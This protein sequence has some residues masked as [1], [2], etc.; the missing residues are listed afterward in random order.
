[1]SYLDETGLSALWSKIKSYVATHGGGSALSAYPVGSIYISVNATNPGTIFGGTWEAWGA[2]R[3]P[4]GVNP[5]DGDF[6]AP[7]K[8]GGAKTVTLTEAQ[9]PSHSH[10]GRFLNAWTASGHGSG[11]WFA[12]SAYH[13]GSNQDYNDIPGVTN[14]VGGGKPHQN[15]PPYITCYMYKRTA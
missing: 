15:M 6:N 14:S 4:V 3:V 11:N 5:N 9:M 12:S 7:N 10:S 13:W 8:T 2:G 1:M